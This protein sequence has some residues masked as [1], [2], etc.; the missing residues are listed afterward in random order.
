MMAREVRDVTQPWVCPICFEAVDGDNGDVVSIAC[1]D[2]HRFCRLCL[3]QHVDSQPFPR[4]PAV[5]CAYELSEQD[6]IVIC[7]AGS[8]RVERFREDLLTK[9]TEQCSNK[10]VG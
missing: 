2:E 1:A 8:Q 4:C 6:L 5:R 9:A 3:L 10:A 7:G